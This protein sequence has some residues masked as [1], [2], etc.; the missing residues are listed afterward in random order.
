MNSYSIVGWSVDVI[1]HFHFWK[2]FLG[3]EAWTL[4]WL[5]PSSP[6][7]MLLHCLLT[8]SDEKSNIIFIFIFCLYCLFLLTSLEMFF[9]FNGVE[10]FNSDV[11]PCGLFNVSCAHNVH[12]ALW[13]FLSMFLKKLFLPFWSFQKLQITHILDLLNIPYPSD[14]LCS[15]KNIF[16]VCVWFHFGYGQFFMALC[17]LIFPQPHPI[18]QQH[19]ICY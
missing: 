7:K 18:H 8:A 19:L 10:Q 6:L 13:K 3:E 12:L 4:G 2:T 14:M 1:F 9:F 15:L 5:L 17:S 11:A 16:F